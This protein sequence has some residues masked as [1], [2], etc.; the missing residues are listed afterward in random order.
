MML[1]EETA[2]EVGIADRTD[3]EDSIL[4][5]ARYVLKVREQLPEG[6]TEPD[7]TW[8]ALAAYNVG[9]G[10]LQDARA[11]TRKR[12]GDPDRWLDVKRALPLLSQERWYKQVRHGYA[13]G[14]VPVHY[15]ENIRNYYELLMWATR[16]APAERT[17]EFPL[18]AQNDS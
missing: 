10:H 2:R 16:D 18:L 17:P 9:L 6:I 8:M 5:G 4:G 13:A 14:K 12:G 15:V 7:R 3:P 11:L 1:T